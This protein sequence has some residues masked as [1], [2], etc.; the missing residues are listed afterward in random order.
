MKDIIY[1]RFFLMFLHLFFFITTRNSHIVII[2][3]V[4]I[5]KERSGGKDVMLLGDFALKPSEN[6]NS[7]TFFFFLPDSNKSYIILNVF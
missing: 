4:M 3:L 1:T 2:N 5:I 6:F 7:S